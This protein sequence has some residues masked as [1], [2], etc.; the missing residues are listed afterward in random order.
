MNMKEGNVKD[1]SCHYVNGGKEYE[2]HVMM[3]MKEGNVKDKP[4]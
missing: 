1:V 2:G 3:K 4:Y